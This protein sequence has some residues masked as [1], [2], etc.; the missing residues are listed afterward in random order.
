[1][2]KTN[3]SSVAS[4]YSLDHRTRIRTGSIFHASFPAK[5]NIKHTG[6]P[7]MHTDMDAKPFATYVNC[8]HNIIGKDM[9]VAAWTTVPF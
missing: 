6:M 5:T 9:E 2:A 4:S 7:D 1:M 3:I 8:Y